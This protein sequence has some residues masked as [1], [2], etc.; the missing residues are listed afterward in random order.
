[1]ITRERF[2]R[3]SLS[4]LKRV[5]FNRGQRMNAPG[6]SPAPWK[7][8]SSFWFSPLAPMGKPGDNAQAIYKC[9]L[10]RA[11]KRPYDKHNLL[12]TFYRDKS[13]P[14]KYDPK[15]SM[16]RDQNKNLLSTRKEQLRKKKEEMKTVQSLGPTSS[17]SQQSIEGNEDKIGPSEISDERPEAQLDQDKS[18][19]C[20]KPA[21]QDSQSSELANE[22]L[23]IDA[24]LVCY[25][26]PFKRT[27]VSNESD[28][29]NTSTVAYSRPNTPD[30][31]T[32]QDGVRKSFSNILDE[33]T[34]ADA[35]M[36]P[37]S[38][39]PPVQD[40]KLQVMMDVISSLPKPLLQM[41]PEDKKAK[42]RC[43]VEIP[44]QRY[45]KLVRKF[46]LKP[47]KVML[48]DIVKQG[49]FN[50]ISSGTN[51]KDSQN[52]HSRQTKKQRPGWRNMVIKD[53]DNSFGQQKPAGIA[54]IGYRYRG[55]SALRT[56]SED[57]GN[58]PGDPNNTE[59][60]RSSPEGE[61][62]GRN[63][64]TL[65]DLQN[66]SP[67]RVLEPTKSS[68]DAH[69]TDSNILPIDPVPHEDRPVSPVPSSGSP[70]DAQSDSSPLPLP[71]VGNISVASPKMTIQTEC[72]NSPANLVHNVDT[73][74]KEPALSEPALLEVD[75]NE[76]LVGTEI[77]SAESER[78]KIDDL[79]QGGGETGSW[80]ELPIGTTSSSPPRIEHNI[81]NN[82][83]VLKLCESYRSSAVRRS[84]AREKKVKRCLHCKDC[85]L[86]GVNKHSKSIRHKHVDL[87]KNSDYMQKKCSHNM[88]HSKGGYAENVKP[89][90]KSSKNSVPSLK[91][92]E[93]IA[94]SHKDVNI[95][96]SDKVPLKSATNS[97]PN[98]E[99]AQNIVE[100]RPNR[101]VSPCQEGENEWLPTIV[102]ICSLA[103][104]TKSAD[105]G[106][107][108]S[109]ENA[110]NVAHT[111]KSSVMMINASSSS[112]IRQLSSFPVMNNASKQFKENI[113]TLKGA[114]V[115]ECSVVL[116]D[117][118]KTTKVLPANG[119][120][121]ASSSISSK[122]PL[123]GVDRE[124]T[125]VN[126]GTLLSSSTNVPKNVA[127]P[128]AERDRS[129][130]FFE[131]LKDTNAVKNLVSDE[132]KKTPTGRRMH[133]TLHKPWSH[134][135][136][137]VDLVKNLKP[138]VYPF[139][140]QRPKNQKD[141]N[142]N[143]STKPL[144]F[145]DNELE[146][147]EQ[148][149]STNLQEVK[150]PSQNADKLVCLSQSNAR[151]IGDGAVALQP[152][153]EKGLLSNKDSAFTGISRNGEVQPY[154]A[155]KGDGV[156]EDKTET[157]QY[158]NNG[159]LLIK[160]FTHS[161][162][163]MYTTKLIL[164]F[165]ICIGKDLTLGNRHSQL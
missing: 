145:T 15:R 140:R 161:K 58:S 49:N 26:L 39:T 116:H 117:I 43:V 16:K 53:L 18:Q 152:C 151:V 36:K 163:D 70:E 30:G 14:K 127:A 37:V 134:K 92:K 78:D 138:L 149:S 25:Q 62:S 64:E 80:C 48:V 24:P 105:P 4:P 130:P 160:I 69:P 164:I 124:S 60:Q 17:G 111:E 144:G 128:F 142:D 122:V 84:S 73:S 100:E 55:E 102:K 156:N 129:H 51:N 75:P 98:T 115:S 136:K 85:H 90:S 20:Q 11:C 40:E 132:V 93:H 118:L 104:N 21:D 148:C 44:S 107:Q 41:G 121:L 66:L 52:E 9:I 123:K 139:T 141:D 131:R 3:K 159:L 13:S 135:L 147:T 47:C 86:L 101:S 76:T 158:D 120:G 137:T 57:E 91:S 27:I 109:H 19:E 133:S 12:M 88:A 22:G 32:N 63:L 38:K 153:S 10:K 95:T 35:K 6:A 89:G 5:G 126:N 146:T 96:W 54:P 29:S 82:F 154:T 157:G 106:S 72:D 97:A 50:E 87:R 79:E 119:N 77:S 71:T 34:N 61:N 150:V 45:A 65:L 56:F 108:I 42:K 7:S 94:E 59:S 31:N 143:V 99:N 162:R 28:V 112:N 23:S 114:P 155:C 8:P 74:P 67:P 110:E 83:D 2:Q 33:G 81:S 46:K 113:Q 165:T 1:M 68:I 125:N 103:P